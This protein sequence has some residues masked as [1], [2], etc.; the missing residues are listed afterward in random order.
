MWTRKDVLTLIR[1]YEARPFLWDTRNYEYKDKNKNCSAWQDIADVLS[2]DFHEVQR[3]MKI[4]LT[5]YRRENMKVS[6]MQKAGTY[7]ENE[8]L[9]KWFAYDCLRFIDE[10]PKRNRR[11]SFHCTSSSIDNKTET[12]STDSFEPVAQTFCKVEQ[13]SQSLEKQTFETEINRV[14]K[15]A[16]AAV[17]LSKATSSPT[18]VPAIK[19]V[20]KTDSFERDED[21]I[22]GEYIT[23]RLKKITDA[24]TK[25]IVHQEINNILFKA[26]MGEI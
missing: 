10:V 2:M 26:E 25:C 24:R 12:R 19:P 21:T 8:K 16:V 1:E 20:N 7:S 17:N 3:K 23:R 18:P 13:P 14:I 9:T 15:T 11:P 22:F 6:L 4:I 5:Q